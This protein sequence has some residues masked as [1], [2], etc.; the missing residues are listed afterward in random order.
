MCS[1]PNAEQTGSS[2]RQCLGLAGAG[3][4]ENYRGR[5]RRVGSEPCVGKVEDAF[6]AAGTPHS[7]FGGIQINM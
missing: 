7:L 2:G 3:S 1:I 6:S 4:Q 5:E